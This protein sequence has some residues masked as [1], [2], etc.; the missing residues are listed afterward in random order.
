AESNQIKKHSKTITMHNITQPVLPSVS[1][2]TSEDDRMSVITN[3]TQRTNVTDVSIKTLKS[4]FYSQ[5][6]SKQIEL[7]LAFLYHT[8]E[9][10]EIWKDP[11]K[12]DGFESMD[13]LPMPK[14]P[15]RN[16]W[17]TMTRTAWAFSPRLAIQ[18]F[19]RFPVDFIRVRSEE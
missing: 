4:G 16:Q 19:N 13:P 12:P 14:Q 1:D 11:I 8:F 10:M 18:L 7:I 3:T 2:T 17:V 15:S 6:A 5:K 9:R